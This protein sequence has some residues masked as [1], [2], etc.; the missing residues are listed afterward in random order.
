MIGCDVSYKNKKNKLKLNRITGLD[1]LWCNCSKEVTKFSVQVW[2][3]GLLLL[4]LLLILVSR[5][6]K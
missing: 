6:K 2:Y 4:L 5:E 3:T 1:E